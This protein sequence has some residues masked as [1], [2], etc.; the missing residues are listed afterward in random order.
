MKQGDEPT[1]ALDYETG[2]QVLNLLQEASVEMGTTVVIITHN[3]QIAAIANRVI[4]INDAKVREIK[5]N[6]NPVSV[7]DITW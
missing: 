6:Q 1:G 7:M 3:S 2:R 5:E 4:S